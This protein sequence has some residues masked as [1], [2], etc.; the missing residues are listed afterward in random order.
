[1]NNAYF[2]LPDSEDIKTS[3]DVIDFFNKK[4]LESDNQEFSDIEIKPDPWGYSDDNTGMHRPV[5]QNGSGTHTEFM[6]LTEIKDAVFGPTGDN[7]D[8]WLRVRLGNP[9]AGFSKALT[10]ITKNMDG[11]AAP[12]SK[13]FSR[14]CTGDS[15][16][17]LLGGEQNKKEYS[18]SEIVTILNRLSD[19]KKKIKE[20]T[21][22][23]EIRRQIAE[24]LKVDSHI[25]PDGVITIPEK[26]TYIVDFSRGQPSP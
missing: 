3:R 17:L 14:V 21:P 26:P 8:S 16:Y 22:D 6:V 1:M 4:F 19:G 7:R 2:Y 9:K 15:L 20:S 11:W 25:S 13:S 24:K 5:I 12:D 23:D 18:R 10:E